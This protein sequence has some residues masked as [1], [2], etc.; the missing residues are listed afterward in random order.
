MNT[1][2]EESLELL[3]DEEVLEGWMLKKMSGFSIEWLIKCFINDELQD[4]MNSFWAIDNLDI[5]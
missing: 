2:C 3:I 5:L 1:N 4:I